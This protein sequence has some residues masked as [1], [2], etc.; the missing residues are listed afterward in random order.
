MSTSTLTAPIIW[1]ASSR[2]GLAWA[3]AVSRL[4]SGRSM[5]ISSPTCGW[6][7]CRA[8]AIQQF[9][10]AMGDPSGAKSLNEPQKRSTGS[11]NFGS[12]PQSCTACW[13]K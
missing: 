9:S 6:P 3:S 1:P 11:F 8:N 13:L 5:T 7:V 2:N 10:W 12:R 4:P